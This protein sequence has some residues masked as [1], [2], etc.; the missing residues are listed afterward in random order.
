LSNLGVILDQQDLHGLASAGVIALRG[1]TQ[2]AA[3]G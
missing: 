2:A 3:L 1:G